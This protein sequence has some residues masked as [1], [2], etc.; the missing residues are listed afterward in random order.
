SQ[1][2]VGGSLYGV[3]VRGG[4]ADPVP[5]VR[6]Q[7][8]SSRAMGSGGVACGRASALG[9]VGEA[10]ETRKDIP[11]TTPA[12]SAKLVRCSKPRIRSENCRLLARSVAPDLDVV[13]AGHRRTH[14]APFRVYRAS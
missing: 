9:G 10:E 5:L 12:A 14:G 1:V 6:S 13:Y 2:P 8:V 7:L 3:F 11:R 4:P